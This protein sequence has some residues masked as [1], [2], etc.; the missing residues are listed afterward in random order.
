MSKYSLLVIF[1]PL[2][3]S[4][5][6]AQKSATMDTTMKDSVRRP[7]I[8]VE[9]KKRRRVREHALFLMRLTW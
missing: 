7:N 6:R 8:L 4:T 1:G 2:V 5:D 3:A 9:V